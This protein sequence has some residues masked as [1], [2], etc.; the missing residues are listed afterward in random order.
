[1]LILLEMYFVGMTAQ[2]D[3]VSHYK[4]TNSSYLRGLDFVITSRSMVTGSD[5]D[6]SSLTSKTCS[7][8]N[9]WAPSLHGSRVRICTLLGNTFVSPDFLFQ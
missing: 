7:K 8:R 9:K 3:F 6:A 2:N 5:N 4:K 1:M